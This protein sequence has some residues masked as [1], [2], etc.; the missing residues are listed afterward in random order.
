MCYTS[1]KNTWMTREIFCYWLQRFNE[2]ARS[3]GHHV[4]L[5][6]DNCTAHR[7]E[8]IWLMHMELKFLPPSSEKPVGGHSVRT[9]FCMGSSFGSVFWIIIDSGARFIHTIGLT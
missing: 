1:N 8:D 2:Q 6:L 3:A 5:L 7:V 4:C 9:C